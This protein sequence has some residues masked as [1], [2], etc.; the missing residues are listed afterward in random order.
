MG[1]ELRQ[2]SIMER[3]Q[4]CDQ[5]PGLANAKHESSLFI[6]ETSE[7]TLR[8]FLERRRTWRAAEINQPVRVPEATVGPVLVPR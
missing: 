2:E 3:E 5:A 7:T 1:H 8:S 6:A 4:K